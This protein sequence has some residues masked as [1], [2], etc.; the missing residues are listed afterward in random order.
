MDNNSN[1]CTCDLSE[2]Q[3]FGWIQKCKLWTFFGVVAYWPRCCI[4]VTSAIMVANLHQT[5]IPRAAF[6]IVAT[7]QILKGIRKCKNRCLFQIEPM[8]CLTSN[9]FWSNFHHIASVDEYTNKLMQNTSKNKFFKTFSAKSQ[10]GGA[11]KKKRV[12]SYWV[13]VRFDR[14]AWNAVYAPCVTLVK[15]RVDHPVVRCNPTL[16]YGE[17]IHI[18]S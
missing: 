10:A 13:P 18:S 9:W 16:Q 4:N 15:M 7:R 1:P 2:L 6:K 5:L 11:S 3:F 8:W 12:T 17:I 14:H